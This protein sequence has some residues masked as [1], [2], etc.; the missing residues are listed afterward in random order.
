ML[1]SRG[2]D[3]A[4]GVSC[5]DHLACAQNDIV[6]LSLLLPRWQVLALESV[7]RQ[8]GITA[9]HMLRRIVAKLLDVAPTD[10]LLES[11]VEF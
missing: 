11:D 7:A 2:V 6:E 5:S 4:A 8:N 9:G 3:S 1:H 10:R